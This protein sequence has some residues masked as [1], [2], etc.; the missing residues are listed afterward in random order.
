MPLVQLYDNPSLKWLSHKY[1]VTSFLWRSV[2]PLTYINWTQLDLDNGALIINCAQFNQCECVSLDWLQSLVASALDYFLHARDDAVWNT[3]RVLF[4]EMQSPQRDWWYMPWWFIISSCIRHPSDS[5]SDTH[6]SSVKM[7]TWCC[8]CLT[9]RGAILKWIYRS[10][11]VMDSYEWAYKKSNA[12][13][14]CLQNIHGFPCF[15]NCFSKNFNTI[16]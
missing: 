4:C 12:S 10:N 2:Q 3:R 11:Y 8:S 9:H 14:W 16:Q 15:K 5:F 13:L 1:K 6:C 7:C